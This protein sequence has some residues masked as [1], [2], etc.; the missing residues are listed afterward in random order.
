MRIIKETHIDFIS[1]TRLTGILSLV[2]IIVGL[3]TM[4]MKGGPKLSID[5][6]GGSMIAVNYTEPVDIDEVRTALNQVTI[7]GQSF[8]FSHVEIKH[9]GDESNVAVRLPSMEDEP[10][11]FAHKFVEKMAEAFPKL[12][13]ENQSDFILS[14]EKVGPKV[15][16]ELSG[17][18]IMA[19]FSALALILIYISI[20]FEFKY[21]VGAIAA[22]TH[23]IL[24]TLGIFSI[25]DFEISLAVI[26]AFLTIV[27]YSLND[28]IVIFDRIRENVKGLKK[29]SLSSVIN[30][31]INQSLSRTIIT[32]LTTFFVVMILFLVGGEVIH[33]FAFAMIIGVIVG[34]YSSIFVASPVI[35]KM[36]SD[37]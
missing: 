2:L 26:A 15:G 11:Q 9:F 8:D 19:I 5:F 35:I 23:D 27:G 16:A 25:L 13:P 28:T 3:A 10:E 1:K 37:N 14:I 4:F 17:D 32:S 22:L 12:V 29:A 7:D 24:I 34:T 33:T 31:S 6:K 36:D 21:A 30:E 18:A 20:R